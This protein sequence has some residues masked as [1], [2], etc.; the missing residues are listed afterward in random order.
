MK[1][2]NLFRRVCARGGYILLLACLLVLPGL[3]LS[4]QDAQGAKR[5]GNTNPSDKLTLFGNPGERMQII[6][7]LLREAG[8]KV[9]EQKRML[10]DVVAR[11]VANE[12][13]LKVSSLQAEE[14]EKIR[15][16][17]I[18]NFREIET[19]RERVARIQSDTAQQVYT[20]EQTFHQNMTTDIARKRTR[21]AQSPAEYWLEIRKLLFSPSEQS[22]LLPESE[23]RTFYR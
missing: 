14:R 6:G 19:I 9:M 20:I 1:L 16:E 10:D 3:A 15:Q 7:R 21:I 2:K 17:N 11:I 5:G 12:R 8:E 13:R 22:S 4:A 23:A 18:A